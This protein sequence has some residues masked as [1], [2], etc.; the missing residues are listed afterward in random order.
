MPCADV[1][2]IGAGQAGLAMSRELAAL[3]IE[4]VILERGRV[5]ERWRTTTWDSLRLLTPNWMTRL[6]DWRY[7]GTDPDGYMTRDAV[8]QFLSGY[9]GAIAAPIISASPVTR[10][11]AVGGGYAVFTPA[12]AW[13]CRALVIATG[14]CDL[15]CLP[16]PAGDIDPSV[17][18]L[19]S[20][21][22]RNP[23]AL[24]A[25]N[26][27]VVGAS[28]S[29]AQIALELALSGRSVTLAVGR[30]TPLPRLWLGRDIFY[31]LDRMGT[32][33]APARSLSDLDAARN[34]PSL[35][36]TG[37]T[38]GLGVDLATLE[39]HG[40][41]LTGRLGAAA[42]HTVHFQDGLS[43]TIAYA[44][45]KRDRLL[46]DISRLARAQPLPAETSVLSPFVPTSPP[47][48]ID[49]R[50]ESIR[51]VIWATGFRRNFTWLRLPI[52][53]EH[54]ELAHRGGETAVRG[55]YALGFR[56]LRRRN[57]SFIDGVGADAAHLAGR[58]AERLGASHRKAA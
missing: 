38:N 11:E 53:D 30:H 18:Q 55:V 31:W 27:L 21:H 33:A 47:K 12:G 1:V 35:Q 5:A 3:G 26:V 40:V 20:S 39:K 2:I 7:R 52:L 49:L 51:T 41:R 8:I 29:G 43:A 50:S 15:P 45:A 44:E 54:G 48:T 34:Q 37:R 6:P 16:A 57:S 23:S 58:I 14:H 36:L 10:V 19:H 22:Y 28:A 17:I 32:L 25:G 56:F 13:N 9:A 4:N 46:G 24:A 42:G